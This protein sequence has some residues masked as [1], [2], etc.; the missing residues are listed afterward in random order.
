MS[1]LSTEFETTNNS[2]LLGAAAAPATSALANSSSFYTTFGAIVAG[3]SEA[4]TQF[5]IHLAFTA[6]KLGIMISANTI[7]TGSGSTFT[8]RKNGANGNQ[9]VSIPTSTTGYFEDT[10]DTDSIASGDLITSQ[11]SGG[12]TG[13]ATSASIAIIEMMGATPATATKLPPPIFILQAVNRAATI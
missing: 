4:A 6:S 12:G 9:T 13:T 5:K 8:F 2:F 3:G 7:A 10:V 1:G 11:F